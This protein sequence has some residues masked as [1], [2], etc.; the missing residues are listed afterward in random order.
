MFPSEGALYDNSTYHALMN[1]L[2]VILEEM[3]QG[4]QNSQWLQGRGF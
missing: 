4:I 2:Y 1:Q 3:P